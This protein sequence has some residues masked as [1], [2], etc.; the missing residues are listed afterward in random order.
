[1]GQLQVVRFIMPLYWLFISGTRPQVSVCK[2][3]VGPVPLSTHIS[4]N[5]GWGSKDRFIVD[6][7]DGILITKPQG[8]IIPNPCKAYHIRG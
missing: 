6:D 2:L 8:F 5:G 4:K 3:R 1:M 7:N